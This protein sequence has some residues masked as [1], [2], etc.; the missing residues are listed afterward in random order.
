M[1]GIWDVLS[2]VDEVMMSV[3]GCD[4]WVCVRCVCE[5][6]FEGSM[7]VCRWGTFVGMASMSTDAG[8]ME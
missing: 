2:V 5:A 7:L 4:V 3:R 8:G 1:K 6:S